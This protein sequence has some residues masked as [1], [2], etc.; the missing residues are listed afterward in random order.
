MAGI[1]IGKCGRNVLFSD[2][3][4]VQG[5]GTGCS[6]VRADPVCSGYVVRRRRLCRAR[7]ISKQ[8]FLSP[9][10]THGLLR[11]CAWPCRPGRCVLLVILLPLLLFLEQS[12]P[13]MVHSRGSLS[14]RH[15]LCQRN[16]PTNQPT[17]PPPTLLRSR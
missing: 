1:T 8:L 6:V 2:G 15:E 3:V 11:G 17:N 16:Q 9:S 13:D 12:S 10:Q 7:P 5:P 4:D 14:P